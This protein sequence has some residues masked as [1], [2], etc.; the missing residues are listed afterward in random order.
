MRHL[1]RLPRYL[2]ASYLLLT[3]YVGL[4][5]FAGWA[6]SGVSPLAFITEPW[7]KYI[8]RPDVW[9]NIAGFMPFGFTLA[10]CLLGKAKPGRVVLGVM[11]VSFAL[12]FLIEFTQNWLPGRI[13]SNLDLAT[14]VLGGALGAFAGL[15]WGVI[16][17][18]EGLIQRWRSRQV[19]SGHIGEV[20]LL[21]IALW[22]LSQLEPTSLLFGAGDL[23]AL[24]DLPAPMAFSPRRYVLLETA[25]VASSTLALG[26]LLQR[27]LREPSIWFLPVVLLVG[28]ALRSVSNTLFLTPSDPLQWATPGALRGLLLGGVLLLVV[29]R[30]PRWSRHALVSLTLLLSTA[31]VNLAPDNPFI[32]ASVRTVQQG[33]FLNFYGLTQLATVLWPFLALAW[34]SAQAAVRRW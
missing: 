34:L 8:S 3:L 24:F 26:L 2:C 29:G 6:D 7:Q 33:H 1:T 11:L 14:N 23:R 20:G 17:A 27:C 30:L 25:A 10:A 9:L 32:D 19:L 4:H 5:P 18:E 16:F 31:L 28:L 13:S 15:R 21:L 22:W 12:S